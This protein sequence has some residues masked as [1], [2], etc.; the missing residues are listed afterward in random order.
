MNDPDHPWTP[1]AKK[2]MAFAL[3]IAKAHGH[4][5]IGAEHLLLGILREKDGK[6]AQLLA[7]IGLEEASAIEFFRWGEEPELSN[8]MKEFLRLKKKLGL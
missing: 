8:D 2:C 3:K 1:R 5:Y 7:S 4:G 6:A